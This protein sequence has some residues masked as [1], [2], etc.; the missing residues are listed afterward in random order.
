MSRFLLSQRSALFII[1]SLFC[2][3]LYSD[4][5]ANAQES[6]IC[7]DDIEKYCKEIKPG[8]GRIL[9]CLKAHEN[10]LSV[11]CRGKIHELQGFIKECEQA[12]AGDI[13]QFCKEIQPGGGRII[14]C[15]RERD[16]ELSPS[17]S[18]KLEMIGKRFQKRGEER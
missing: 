13:A 2:V 12:C 15:L 9:N 18:A 17:C 6:L 8:G 14:K 10:E 11:S 5:Q 3:V 4:S 16:K 1:V 7:A